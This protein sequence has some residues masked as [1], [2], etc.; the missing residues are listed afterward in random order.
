MKNIK[1]ISKNIETINSKKIIISVF[2][3]ELS[4]GEFDLIKAKE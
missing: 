3:H 1:V 4:G 2:Y